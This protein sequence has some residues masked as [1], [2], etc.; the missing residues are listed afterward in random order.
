[1]QILLVDDDAFSRKLMG[2]YLKPLDATV[3]MAAG[4]QECLDKVAQGR[5]DLIL[6]DCQMPE[7]DGFETVTRLRANGFTGVIL[8]LTGNSD[9]Q[10][11]Q[12][13]SEVGMNGHMSK[14]VDPANLRDQ[15]LAAMGAAP[16][17]APVVVED[18]LA[19][20]RAIAT[21]ARNPALMGRLVASFVKST[22]D[23]LAQLGHAAHDQDGPAV[24]AVAHRLR[25][26]SGTFGAITFSQTA[27]KLEDSLQ[28]QPLSQCLPLLEQLLGMWPA[29]KSQLEISGG[30]P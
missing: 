27:G 14:P 24:A 10:T 5:P 23:G 4:G 28:T 17:A 20:A 29:L 30:T 2:Y 22:E 18:P 21:A 15:I 16:A 3:D 8:A 13:C 11:L 9:P 25:G 7:M 6:M 1:M 19:R 26:S 12:R